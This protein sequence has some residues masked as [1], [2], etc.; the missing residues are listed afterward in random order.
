MIFEVKSMSV[1]GRYDNLMNVYRKDD[2]AIVTP[3]IGFCFGIDRIL[4]LVDRQEQVYPIRIWVSI[5]GKLKDS[6]P[7]LIKLEIVDKLTKR[8]FNVLYNLSDRSFKKEIMDAL[9]KKCDFVIMIGQTEIDAR[10]FS[11]K[12]LDTH[13]QVLV[14]IDQLETY[15]N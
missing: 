6:N 2:N 11:V 10:S 15:F 1:D 8:G 9:D 14:P 3:M 5:I 13:E 4:P 7:T 12:N